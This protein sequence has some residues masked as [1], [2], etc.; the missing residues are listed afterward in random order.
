MNFISALCSNSVASPQAAKIVNFI[1]LSTNGIVAALV[2]IEFKAIDKAF[3]ITNIENH[4]V[5]S[6]TALNLNPLWILAFL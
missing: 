4:L 2:C 1:L 6:F 3:A 5:Y